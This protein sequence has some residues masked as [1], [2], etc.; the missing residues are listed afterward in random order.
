MCCCFVVLLGHS[1]FAQQAPSNATKELDSLSTKMEST[2]K[3]LS[4]K[5]SKKISVERD[6]NKLVRDLKFAE[7]K[8]VRARKESQDSQKK[9]NST[10]Q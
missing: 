10:L 7:L 6:Y 8:L 2:R 5:K 3:K 9:L 4:T 1:G